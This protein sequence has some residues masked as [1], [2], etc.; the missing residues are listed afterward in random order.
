MA[1]PV[2]ILPEDVN[3]LQEIQNKQLLLKEELVNIGILKLNIKKR[4]KNIEI[5]HENLVSIETALGQKMKQVYGDGR[6]DY[7]KWEFIP[8]KSSK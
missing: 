8:K 5:F 7:D 3:A 6:I 1:K 4:E 2:K